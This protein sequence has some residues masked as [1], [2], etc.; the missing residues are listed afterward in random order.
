MKPFKKV[1][2][3]NHVW[4][5]KWRQIE[6]TGGTFLYGRTSPRT[7]TIEINDNGVSKS[8]QRDAVMHEI[9]HAVFSDIPLPWTDDFDSE[10]VIRALTPGLL[11]ALRRN[12]DVVDYILGV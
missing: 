12:P 8:Q 1:L 7:T 11:E 9:M 10:T 2:I 3:G 4:K 5:V 6:D